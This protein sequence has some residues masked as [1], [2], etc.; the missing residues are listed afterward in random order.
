M[1]HALTLVTAPAGFGKTTIVTS[2]AQTRPIS[3]AWLSLHPTDRL[4]DRFITYLIQALQT[5][6]P[7][8]GQ[9]TLALLQNASIEGAL[10]AFVNDLAEVEKD[11]VLVL[12]DFHNVD[13]PEISEILQFILDNRPGVFH[14]II[15]TRATPNMNLYRLRALGQVNEIDESDLRFT[16]LEVRQFLETSMGLSLTADEISRLNQ[17]T[18]GWAVGLQ[19]AA[20]ALTRQPADWSALTGREHIF[21][22]L[23][24]EVLS[25]ETFE[26]QNFLK[27]SAL[28]D[29]FSENLISF[30]ARKLPNSPLF[31]KLNHLSTPGQKHTKE[32]IDY[33]ERANL[34]L[35][36]LD[37]IR[38]WFRYHALFT[39]YLR[40]QIGPEMSLPFYRAASEWFESEGS[41]DD[42]VQYASQACDYERAAY[43]LENHYISLIKRGEQASLKNWITSLPDEVVRKHPQL[44]LA[45]G[46]AEAVMLDTIKARE[47][48]DKAEALLPPGKAGDRLRG[49]AE[50]LRILC[51]IFMGNITSIERIMEYKTSIVGEDDLQVLFHFSLASLHMMRGETILA[52]DALQDTLRLTE[53][54]PNPI[55]TINANVMLSEM[56]LM[57]GALG[58]AERNYHQLIRFAKETL[59]EHTYLL[60]LPY[61]SFADLLRE[62]NRFEDAI[63]YAEKGITYCRTWHCLASMDGEI[64]LARIIAATGRWNEAYDKLEEIIQAAEPSVSVLDYH[65]IALHMARMALLQGD[66]DRAE[67]YISVYNLKNACQNM[68]YHN[69]EFCCLV[70]LRAQVISLA[71]DLSPASQILDD[72]S[73]QIAESERRERISAVIEGSILLSYVQHA[74]SKKDESA[75]SL[76]H[77]LTLGA[78][79]G[80]VRLFADEGERLLNLINQYQNQIRAPS[81]Y[82]E[83]IRNTLESEA[84]RRNS[85][86]PQDPHVFPDVNTRIPL[87]WRE[88][89]ILPLLAAGKSNQEIARERVLAI[90]T[91]KKHVANIISKLG[92]SN[93][94]Q[95]V[96]MAK[97][98]GWIE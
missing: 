39:D 28:F 48:A 83:R 95:A 98:M 92:V 17:T 52:V 93:R 13:C 12:D 59:G 16:E 69:A 10:Y 20:L 36:P 58:L 6:S 80:Y 75:Q 23:A 88:L 8:F 40:R 85:L 34:F 97:K 55:I 70:F 24:E 57:R 78:Q 54:F 33:I 79:C 81:S 5:I 14:L 11:F 74:L 42:A 2:W 94:T 38:T 53:K 51:D 7:K 76:S 47:C 45:M 41:L 4:R 18:E 35:V 1:R 90:N 26:V 73:T 29:R 21:E 96:M 27:I 37:P 68:Y 86:S 9:T 89:N 50:S 65:L 62:Q 44:W 46:W 72:L 67:H 25:R 3:I 32:L 64:L 66:I 60:G 71:F 91:V 31:E 84:T 87:T 43:L 63:R 56:R 82:I 22:Y 49:E 15:L 61:I 77:A 30:L 19:L